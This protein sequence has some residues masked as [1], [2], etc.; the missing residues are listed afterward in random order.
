M[1]ESV[2]GP[3]PQSRHMAHSHGHSK[4][5]Q[6]QGSPCQIPRKGRTQRQ[7]A[8]LQREGTNLELLGEGQCRPD[9]GRPGGLPVCL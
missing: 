4:G 2:S 9:L 8:Q 1:R 6:V 7:W 3:G 5:S